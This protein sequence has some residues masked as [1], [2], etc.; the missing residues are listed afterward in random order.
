MCKGTV[1]LGLHLADLFQLVRS[2]CN[3]I[4]ELRPLYS[5]GMIESPWQ[6]WCRSGT[7]T[8]TD[9]LSLPF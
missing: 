4:V 3:A 1:F 6:M 2:L 8:G 7:F 5:H 9:A